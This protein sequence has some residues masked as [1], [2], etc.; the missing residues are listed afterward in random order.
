MIDEK[1]MIMLEAMRNSNIISSSILSE[2]RMNSL[3]DEKIICDYLITNDLTKNFIS[4][5]NRRMAG[6]FLVKDN[7][8]V[9][10]NIKTTFGYTLD[11]A[12]S[13]SI[14]ILSAITF[15]LSIKI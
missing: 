4:I 9:P 12:F 10:Y 3:C 6:D 11:N 1:N 8:L 14:L 15:L 13:K 5:E 2:G 7:V